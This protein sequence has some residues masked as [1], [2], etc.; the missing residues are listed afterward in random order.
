MEKTFLT[1]IFTNVS[2]L[3]LSQASGAHLPTP[4]PIPEAI[5]KSLQLIART[6]PAPA[7][8]GWQNQQNT[9]AWQPQQQIQQP[10][11][12]QWQP[13]AHQKWN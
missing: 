3:I 1:E 11:H 7:T 4:P 9:G 10:Q 8:H 5:Q 6:Q 12:Q 13:Q 2:S